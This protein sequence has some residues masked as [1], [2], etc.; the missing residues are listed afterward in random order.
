M[1]HFHLRRIY[2]CSLCDLRPLMNFF[3]LLCTGALHSHYRYYTALTVYRF[4]L[5]RKL[6]RMYRG[7]NILSDVL[8][9]V[10]DAIYEC[11][12]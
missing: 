3:L 2:R 5:L 8:L 10:Q 4:L 6:N 7:V 11:F 1:L 12:R 9:N